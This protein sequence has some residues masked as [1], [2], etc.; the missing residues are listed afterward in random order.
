VLALRNLRFAVDFGNGGGPPSVGGLDLDH[1]CSREN[2]TPT[3]CV[4][5]ATATPHKDD[6]QGVDNAM[7]WLIADNSD[8]LHE[9]LT[10]NSYP[11]VTLLLR[12]NEYNGRV[13]DDQVGIEVF[14]TGGID[15][16]DDAGVPAVPS[17]TDADTWTV[18]CETLTAGCDAGANSPIVSASVDS[19][20]Y[21]SQ[22]VLVSQNLRSLTVVISSQFPDAGGFFAVPVQLNDPVLVAPLT[23]KGG[24][25]VEIHDGLLGGRWSTADMIAAVASVCIDVNTVEGNI[26]CP[27]AD[28]ASRAGYDGT[29]Q[30][31]RALSVGLTYDAY[32]ATIGAGGP[33]P[34]QYNTPCPGGQMPDCP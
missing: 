7:G 24:G 29:G 9:L 11:G 21:V 16:I 30:P 18:S 28:I 25:V 14:T 31:C 19:M 3:S 13:D 6:G 2:G 20:A 26:V 23:L 10:S 32:G 1:A 4:S 27:H 22:G 34:I 5:K 33:V 17:W 8:Q 15:P 12:L